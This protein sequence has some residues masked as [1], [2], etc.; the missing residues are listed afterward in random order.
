MEKRPFCF[1]AAPT[2]LVRCNRRERRSPNSS[3][4]LWAKCRGW[5]TPFSRGG[6]RAM[7]ACTMATPH[8]FLACVLLGGLLFG[9]SVLAQTSPPKYGIGTTPTS[10]ELRAWDIS[11]GPGGAELPPGQAATKSHAA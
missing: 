2:N 10:E 5:T 8:R 9:A 11:I 6:S 4:C 1:R 3:T 7:G